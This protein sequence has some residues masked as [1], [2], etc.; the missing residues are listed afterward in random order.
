MKR[1]LRAIDDFWFE[2][3]PATRPALLRVLIGAYTLYYLGRRYRMFL[4]VARTDPALFKPVGAVSYLEKPI[5]TSAF[6]GVLVATLAANVAFI[7]G[8]RHRYTGPLF[9]GLLLWVLSYR[10]SWSMIY[11]N[12]NA[13]V[14]HAA[15][16]G[17]SRSADALS[18][19]ALARSLRSPDVRQEANPAGDWRYGWPIRL[20]NTATTLTYFLAGVAKVKGPLGWG[21]AGGET[22][23]SQIGVDGLRKELLGEGAAPLAFTLYDKVG[24]FRMLAA[25]S[26]ALELGAPLALLN[27]KLSRLWAINAFLMHWGIYFTMKITFRYQ[28]AGLI[29][30]P[31]F[32]LDRLVKRFVR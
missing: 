32:D 25:G 14:L 19:D 16:L 11:H 3:A 22:L 29:F 4:K 13:L 12:D 5:P 31:F 26:L 30:S 7:L 24:L 18:V 23:R 21:W 10:N 8:L 20:I 2:E 1:L 9:A 15:I 27:K 17:L 28:L 6:R